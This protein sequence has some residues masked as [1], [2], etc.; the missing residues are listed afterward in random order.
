MLEPAMGAREANDRARRPYQ[1]GG[2]AAPR[3][4]R[5]V[6]EVVR[7]ADRGATVFRH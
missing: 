7:A 5:I 2:F 1:A 4:G 6:G 3:P